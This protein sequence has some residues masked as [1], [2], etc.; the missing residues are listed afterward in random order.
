MKILVADDDRTLCNIL[1]ATFRKRGW[2]AKPALDAMQALMMA[3]QQPRPDMI[4]LDINMP[5]GTGLMTLERLK[6]SSLTADIPVVVV[7]GTTDPEAPRAAKAGGAVAF[8]K[9]PVDA[10]GLA[11][12]IEK[13]FEGRP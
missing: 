1:T 7:S 6:A 8:V 12:A 3:K 9:K 10:E 13:Y 11:R 5:G 4:L 2:E